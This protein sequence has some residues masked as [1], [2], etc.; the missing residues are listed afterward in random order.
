MAGKSKKVDKKYVLSDSTVNCYGFRLLTS[1]YQLADYAKNPIGYYMHNRAAGVV[2]R[3]DNLTIEGDLVTGYPVINLANGRGEQ[4]LDEVESGFLNAASV[5]DIIVL[6]YSME[7]E[8]MLA[9]QTGPTITKWTNKE[10]SLVDVPGNSNALTRLFDAKDNPITLAELPGLSHIPQ[11]FTSN[12]NTEMKKITIPITA[13]LLANLSFGSTAEPKE[14]EVL[15]AIEKLAGEAAKVTGLVTEV[16]NLKDDKQALETKLSELK[17]EGT[18]AKVTAILDKGQDDKKLS[19]EMR[20]TLAA[21][22]ANNPEGL[23]KLVDKMP[24]HQSIVERI[25]D[26]AKEDAEDLS[27]KSWDDLHRAG[28]L[29]DLKREDPEAY[30]AVFK[31]QFGYEPK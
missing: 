28:K 5:G 1:G 10:V 27:G 17:A 30:K 31:A 22:Y 8:M 25:N 2:V 6:E 11:L 12:Q 9:G 19:N 15:L 23:Q 21:D 26:K 4:T 24:K 13:G 16:S 3:W 20:E 14:E 7:P 29:V 18:K